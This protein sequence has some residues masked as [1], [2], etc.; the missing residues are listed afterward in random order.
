MS[1]LFAGCDSNCEQL[2]S[3]GTY[4]TV[5]DLSFMS[6]SVLSPKISYELLKE[7]QITR[8]RSESLCHPLFKEDYIPQPVV[9][10]SPPKWHLGHTTWFFEEFVLKNHFTNYAVFDDDFSFCLSSGELRQYP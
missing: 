10:I 4:I 6:T 5:V 7:Y 8:S 1:A 9:Y 3:F 2:G